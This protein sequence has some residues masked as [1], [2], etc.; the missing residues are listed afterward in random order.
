MSP[1]PLRAVLATLLVAVAAVSIGADSP[2]PT[3]T[4]AGVTVKR[5]VQPVYPEEARDGRFGPLVICSSEMAIDAEGT[6]Y[7]VSPTS[8][9][10]AF[11]Q[12]TKDA[13][14]QWRFEPPPASG[15]RFSI[16]VQYTLYES[17]YRDETCIVPIEEA[18]SGMF[19]LVGGL[20]TEDCVV[21]L[22]RG[23]RPP[24]WPDGIPYGTHCV[25]TL[26]A[27]LNGAK[28]IKVTGC[29][30][31]VADTV[32]ES[33][34]AF[35][36]EPRKNRKTLYELHVLVDPPP[37]KLD[38]PEERVQLHEAEHVPV[39]HHSEVLVKTRQRLDFPSEALRK[40]LNQGTCIAD[41]KIDETGRPTQVW[42]QQCDPVF[43]DATHD[44]LMQWLWDP[45]LVDGKPSA[46]EFVVPVHF[47]VLDEQ[48]AAPEP[49]IDVDSVEFKRR[50]P[51]P[52]YPNDAWIARLGKASCTVSVIVD[53]E[54]TPEDVLPDNCAW[55]FYEET[56]KAVSKWR[57]VPYLADGKAATVRFPLA[58]T[59]DTPTS[60]HGGECA[61][62][63]MVDG[64]K[65]DVVRGTG[66]SGCAATPAGALEVPAGTMCGSRVTV[67][68]T[69]VKK[70]EID[71][72]ATE[73]AVPLEEALKG[74]KYGLVADRPTV[75]RFVVRNAS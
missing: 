60:T 18:W 23:V 69:G 38:V 62:G 44:G 33:L 71:H 55:P 54:G 17:G 73:V 31:I 16:D 7:D 68:A 65:A 10:D 59:F 6:P 70:V 13:L 24:Q 63:V 34:L 29:P 32:S 61:F 9:P 66:P 11:V 64:A 72:C 56:R 28:D 51:E 37:R 15:A 67:D 75:Y 4:E 25:A 53:K 14:L 39:F 2:A 36:F 22:G 58:V 21:H 19:G 74:W 12:P 27:T 57:T 8:C 43:A 50:A 41:V 5:R 35:T 30:Q 49:P 45:P 48:K 1:T 42:A 26:T 40:G 46:A 3:M 47:E 20:R 52:G